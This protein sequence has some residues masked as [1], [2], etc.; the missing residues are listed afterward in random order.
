[1]PS[2][3]RIPDGLPE[4]EF[5]N[6]GI[7]TLR[8][9]EEVG[10]VSEMVLPR[11]ILTV[12]DAPRELA[13]LR[14]RVRTLLTGASENDLGDALLVCNEIATMAWL[15]GR[16][17][18]PMRLLWMKDGNFRSEVD[19]HEAPESWGTSAALLDGVAGGWGVQHGRH[20]ATLW[21]E[22]VIVVTSSS[23]AQDVPDHQS[24]ADAVH[25]SVRAR[26]KTGA[27]QAGQHA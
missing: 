1:M 8:A 5:G 7:L 16:Q 18:C 6:S 2:P 20:G 21:A 26:S 14:R 11:Q 23:P 15:A 24:T 25:V 17:P 13:A 19:L 10:L 22:V 9:T 27:R 3:S 12:V 4:E